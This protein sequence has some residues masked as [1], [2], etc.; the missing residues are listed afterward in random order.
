[1]WT[2]FVGGEFCQ[3]SHGEIMITMAIAW[4]RAAIA[5]AGIGYIVPVEIVLKL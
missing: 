5:V 1:M 2:C 3:V 4:I